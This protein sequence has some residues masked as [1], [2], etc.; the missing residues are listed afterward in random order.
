MFWLFGTD[1]NFNLRIY[2]FNIPEVVAWPY[3][4]LGVVPAKPVY[5]CVRSRS[6]GADIIERCDCKMFDGKVM[7]MGLLTQPF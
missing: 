5:V 1:A 6:H 4:S 2:L 3:I 7:P